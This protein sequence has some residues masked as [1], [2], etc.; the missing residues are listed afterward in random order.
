M[1][2]IKGKT[3]DDDDAL[4]KNQVLLMSAVRGYS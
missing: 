2:G 1:Q 3:H 4:C